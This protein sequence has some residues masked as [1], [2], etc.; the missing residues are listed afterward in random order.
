MKTSL[1]LS[2][3]LLNAI[4]RINKNL[5]VHEVIQPGN[6]EWKKYQLFSKTGWKKHSEL[7]SWSAWKLNEK[8]NLVDFLI[9]LNFWTYSDELK[10]IYR[11]KNQF[12]RN[13]IERR[14]DWPESLKAPG[15][16]NA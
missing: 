5:S 9:Q 11:P 4:R 13:I 8:C 12:T 16:K 6:N 1:P 3:I 14:R 10:T 2:I 15:E 7:T